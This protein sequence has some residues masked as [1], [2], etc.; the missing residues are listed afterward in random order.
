MIDENELLDIENIEVMLLLDAVYLKY[1]Y[2]FKNY[3]KNHIKRRIK[4]RMGLDNLTSISHM[5]EKLLRDKQFFE[6]LL[7][8]LS[9]NTTEMFRFPTFYSA[10]RNEII[11]V[12]R[13]YPSIK[14]WHAGCSTGEEVFSMGI[15]LQEEGLL[16]RTQIYATDMNPRVLEVAKEGIY[17]AKNVKLWTENYQHSGG[18]N[19]FSDYYIAKYDKVVFDSNLIKHV[20]FS[21][22][23][24][25][26][27]GS[28]VEAHLVICRNVLI[29]FDNTLQNHALELFHESMVPGGFL[30]LGSKENLKFDGIQKK[31]EMISSTDKVFKK[32]IP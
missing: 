28:F 30:G 1:G 26:T 11:P 5:T 3:T 29:Y 12:L 19:S 14:I 10:I 32:K 4:R 24:L 9:I 6:Q 31:F 16:E 18:K 7:A 22:H 21:E 13:T 2:N 20:I 25:V 17:S 23:N 8:D 27:D 15:L